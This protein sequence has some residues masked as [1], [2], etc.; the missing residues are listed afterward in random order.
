MAG[1][2][3][4]HY[5]GKD[6]LYFDHRGLKL[7]LLDNVKRGFQMVKDYSGPE[8]LSLADFTDT[9]ANPEVMAFMTSA[10]S[11]EIEKKIKKQAVLG[12]TGAKKTL[13]DLFNSLTGNKTRTFNT[14]AEAKEWLIQ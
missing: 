9:F 3:I 1:C 4:I 10:E 2:S 6:I 11:K 14:E 13:F 5:K 7:D 8:T 12:I